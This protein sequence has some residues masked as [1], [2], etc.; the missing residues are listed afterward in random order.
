MSVQICTHNRKA[1]LEK[2]L[3]ALLQIDFPSEDYELIL[4]DDGSTDGTGEMVKG[5][6]AECRVTYL[7]QVNSGLAAARNLGIHHAG[8]EVILFMDD[9]TLAHPDLLKEHWAS[10]QQ[11][12]G[13][14]IMGRVH[15]IGD[16]EE[17]RALR[18][19]L[20]DFST[21]FFW[22]SNVS[23]RKSYL[24][25]AGL[26][27][28]DFTE[29]GWEDLEFG[30]RLR[31][32][33]MVRK[34]NRQAIVHHYKPPWRGTDLPR[35][36]RQAQASGRSAVIYLRK[37]A[38]WRTRLSTGIY[39]PHF[40]LNKGLCLGESMCQGVVNRKGGKPLGWFSTICAR[41]LM[42]LSYYD[43]IKAHIK[44]VENGD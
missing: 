36:R 19:K 20:A 2:C 8:G 35:L 5:I 26:F 25:E 33:G 6:E 29:Y 4:V 13:C 44:P 9:D 12:S 30:H 41:L 32:L 42:R 15:H 40:W 39:A 16:L 10:H 22:T 14:V 3:H 23:V 28:E 7:R 38:G 18:Y 21:S 31:D 34:R 43:A 37:R 1:I 27:D 17:A 11:H 24:L